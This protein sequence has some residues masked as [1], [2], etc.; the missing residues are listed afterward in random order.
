MRKTRLGLLL[1][2]A[3][4]VALTLAPAYLIRAQMIPRPTDS[5]PFNFTDLQKLLHKCPARVVTVDSAAVFA[6]TRTSWPGCQYTSLSAALTYIASQNPTTS[7]PWTVLLMP[8]AGTGSGATVANYTEVSLTVPPN[9][10]VQGFSY[11]SGITPT[12]LGTAPIIYLT[13]TSGTG[14]TL[15]GGDTLFNLDIR[16][17][18]TPT[19]AVKVVEANG[20]GQSISIANTQIRVTA[21]SNAFG[22]DGFVNTVGSTYFWNSGVAITGNA[23]GRTV[24]QSG[25]SGITI[26][27][28]RFTGASGCATLM[29]NTSTGVLNLYPGT[30]LD[31]GCT[32]DLKQSSS[33]A[34]TAF[35]GVPYGPIS[36]TISNAQEHASSLMLSNGASVFSGAGA[37][38]GAVTAPIGS[39]WLRTDCT[40]TT[41]CFCVKESGTGNTGWICK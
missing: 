27:S 30:R 13:N 19:A 36:G 17:N 4:A 31:A 33:G 11:G 20:S 2:A 22:V 23:L 28:G 39:L 14:I 40:L 32:T 37:P 41:T 10:A 38:E 24:V 7:T 6:G 15:Q 21:G 8:G 9:T 25:T 18:Q 35:P 26:Y 3:I 1:I 5:G 34:V 12:S 29:E 16:W